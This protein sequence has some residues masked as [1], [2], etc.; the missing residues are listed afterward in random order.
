MRC[1]MNAERFSRREAISAGVAA[2]VGGS[3]AALFARGAGPRQSGRGLRVAVVGAGAFGGW[4]A[5]HLLRSGAEVT[6]FD[7]WGP[8]NSRASSG[9]ETRII[10]AT[11]GADRIY[12]EMVKRSFALW[13]EHEERWSTQLFFRTGALWMS[14]GG[15]SDDFAKQSVPILRDLGFGYEEMDGAGLAR[16]YPQINPEGIGY[17]LFEEEAGYLL[18]RYGCQRVMAAF[19]EE[20]GTYRQQMVRPGAFTGGR[21]GSLSLSDGSS[22][23]ADALVFA[24]GPWLTDLFPGFDP[25]L[26]S[27][28]RQEILYFGAPPNRPE[29]TEGGLPCWVERGEGDLFYYGIPGS[30]YRGFKVADDSRGPA[31]E[32]TS[33]DRTPTLAG[34]ET[35]RR[36]MERRFPGMRGAPLLEARVCQYEQS[37]DAHYIVDRHPEAQDVWIAGGGSGHGYKLGP[38][39][40]EML[41]AQVTGEQEAEPFFSLARFSAARRTSQVG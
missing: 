8:G 34:I 17:A 14:R 15:D 35:A 11:Y 2:G 25:P 24:G 16:R 28:T 20:G 19:R 5:L 1:S 13:R 3:A 22:F 33:G 7:A 29:L 38:A 18:A 31:F 27:P 21:M 30:N 39:L 10:R 12:S 6:L 37:P 32:P 4:T 40:G 26:V 36:Y 41:A 9:G 23:E